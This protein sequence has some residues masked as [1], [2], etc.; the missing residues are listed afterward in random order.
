MSP[1]EFQIPTLLSPLECSQFWNSVKLPPNHPE[2]APDLGWNLAISPL[3]L[4]QMIIEPRNQFLNTKSSSHDFLSISNRSQWSW[5]PNGDTFLNTL[6]YFWWTR[7]KG[8]YVAL[9]ADGTVAIFV[10]F[11]NT[12]FENTWSPQLLTA[13][14]KSLHKFSR[15]EPL[16]QNVK[17]WNAVG[18][19]LANEYPV[20]IRGGGW[21]TFLNLFGEVA[22]KLKKRV[23]FFFHRYDHPVATLYGYEPYY[24][25]TGNFQTLVPGMPSPPRP[26]DWYMILGNSCGELYVEKPIPTAD[27]WQLATQAYFPQECTNSYIDSIANIPWKKRISKAIWRGTLTGCGIN[28]QT[29]MRLKLATMNQPDL[30]NVGLTGWGGRMKVSSGKKVGK[31]P[32]GYLRKKYGLDKL[33][34]MRREEQQQYK[35]VIDLPGNN[36]NPGYRF[37]WEMLAGFVI[38]WVGEPIR[39]KD[40]TGLRRLNLWFWEQLK[41]WEHYVPVSWDLT[42]LEERIQWCQENDAKAEKIA[43]NAQKLAK[44][45]F[46]KENLVKEVVKYF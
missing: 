31:I 12:H 14:Q 8:T 44:K 37:A 20:Q 35:Y 7:G 22:R 28:E 6:G 19:L 11:I 43:K 1:P 17:Q 40:G 16:L 21:G 13:C 5:N 25:L 9:D 38:L 15:Q 41:P 2:V 24:H 46:Q 26:L 27:E 30:M 18:C 42:D 33:E 39:A 32:V 3:E 45:L 29:N 23:D 10:P 4:S 36:E 34:P